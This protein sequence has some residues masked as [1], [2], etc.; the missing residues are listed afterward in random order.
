[1]LGVVGALFL[2]WLMFF[3]ACVFVCVIGAV[4]LI[5][6]A[7]RKEAKRSAASKRHVEN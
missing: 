2:L 4:V 1:M 3:A 5:V 6:R 7:G